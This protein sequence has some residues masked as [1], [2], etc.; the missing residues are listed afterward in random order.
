MPRFR[1]PILALCALLAPCLAAADVLLSASLTDI[2]TR[3]PGGVERRYAI[4]RDTVLLLN[5]K[6]AKPE[7]LNPGMQVSVQASSPGV[8]GRIEA[9][10]KGKLLYSDE[11]Q[12]VRVNTPPRR[13]REVREL[14]TPIGSTPPGRIVSRDTTT[15]VVS[16][17]SGKPNETYMI[18]RKTVVKVEGATGTLEDLRP[19]MEVDVSASPAENG[20]VATSV[21]ATIP[22]KVERK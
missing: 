12:R 22:P 19:G 4:T 2:S 7:N 5:G 14:R 1:L 18:N 6:P 3:N 11:T 9:R 13:T 21:T 10:G 8:A 17:E 15:L 16:G 20:G